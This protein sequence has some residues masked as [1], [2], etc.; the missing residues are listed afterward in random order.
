MPKESPHTHIEPGTHKETFYVP[1]DD[2]NFDPKN[3]RFVDFSASDEMAI[4]KFLYEEADLN[5]LVQSISVSGF[6]DYEPLLVL[7]E[8]SRYIVL[9]GNRRLGAVRLLRSAALQ[10]SLGIPPIPLKTEIQL[11]TNELRV[12]VMDS[13]ESARAFIGFKHINGPQKW[14]SLAKAKYAAEWFTDGGDIQNIAR[15]LG[16]THNTVRRLVFGWLVLKQAENN[17][18]SRDQRTARRFSFSHLYTA[19]S[20]PGYRSYI[21]LSED[22]GDTPLVVNPISLTHLAQLRE[23]MTWLYGDKTTATPALIQSQN[24]DLTRLNEVLQHHEARLTLM[25]GKSLSESYEIIAPKSR[26]FADALID[27]VRSAKEAL[28]FVPEYDLDLTLLENAKSLEKTAR[29]LVRS[30]ETEISEIEKATA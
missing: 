8:K 22:A 7:K 1:A 5:E 13:R 9:E 27:A 23:L 14:D 29:V 28:S 11:S 2:L 26:R 6:I 12:L 18:F 4:I 3:P 16:D 10:K 15:T 25:A 21:G 30:M 17:G 24:P 19:L 20:R